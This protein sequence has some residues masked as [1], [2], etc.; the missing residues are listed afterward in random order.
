MACSGADSGMKICPQVCDTP[1]DCTLGRKSPIL[2][3]ILPNCEYQS[4]SY[5]NAFLS[6]RMRIE[7]KGDG[8]YSY[9]IGVLGKAIPLLVTP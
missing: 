6:I 8:E 5:H 4:K 9:D 2:S 3:R 7:E 1:L